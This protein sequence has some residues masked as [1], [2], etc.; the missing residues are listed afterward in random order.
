MKRSILVLL[1]AAFAL[2]IAPQVRAADTGW[3]LGAGGG[4]GRIGFRIE[5]FT[6]GVNERQ[7]DLKPA[8]KVFAGYMFNPNWGIETAYASLGTFRYQYDAGTGGTASLDYKVRGVSFSGV[9]NA[10]LTDRFSLFA[11]IG[12]FY[13]DV[14]NT[15]TDSNGTLAALLATPGTES[16]KRKTSGTYAIGMQ[17]EMVKHVDWRVEYEDF[18]EVGN[19]SVGR[20]QASMLSTS[21]VF[22]F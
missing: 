20:A 18:R 4:A 17:Y 22:T 5:D 10:P 14:R 7:D 15:V 21:I 3:Y 9:G 1:G 2:C 8:G 6:Q 11:R 19:V 16:K 12:L 13:S